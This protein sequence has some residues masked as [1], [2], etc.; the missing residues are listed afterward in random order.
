[1]KAV[2]I[3][4]KGGPEVLRL[5]ETEQP[6]PGRGEVAVRVRATAVNRADLLQCMGRYPAPP[7]AP[8]DIP[9]LEYAG[10]IIET[11][12]A[13]LSRKAG[14]RVMGL[15]GGGAFAEFLVTH[16]RETV[17]I[18]GGM[19]FEKSAAICWTG[20]LPHR[21]PRSRCHPGVGRRELLAG[22]LRRLCSLR[23]RG[24]GRLDGR[25]RGRARS[26]K[27][28]ARTDCTDWHGDAQSI[29]RG[30]NY[31]RSRLRAA[32]AAL[33]LIRP[34]SSG[35]RCSVSDGSSTARL[36][37]DGQQRQFRKSRVSLVVDA[38]PRSSPKRA[39]CAN[40]CRSRRCESEVPAAAIAAE[41]S[42][43]L[44]DFRP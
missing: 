35:D 41:L 9:G 11:G 14:D 20:P 6:R 34:A 17:P 28:H 39:G 18:P 5:Q 22:D 19:D 8:P 1:M 13:V 21:W 15:V 36:R 29:A 30:E 25:H 16:E 3:V 23:A 42:T 7:G 33:F 40:R 26:W 32:V 4:G 12:P 43:D 37:E 2:R 27:H 38:T 10:E 31:R 24:P 44:R